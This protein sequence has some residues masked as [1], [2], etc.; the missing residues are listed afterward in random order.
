M[1]ELL[2][3]FKIGF[4][5]RLLPKCTPKTK[6]ERP[7]LILLMRFYPWGKYPHPLLF[8]GAA[9]NRGLGTAAVEFFRKDLAILAILR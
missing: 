1:Q 6:Q 5:S 2:C 9:E 4:D 7:H 3:A 8:N